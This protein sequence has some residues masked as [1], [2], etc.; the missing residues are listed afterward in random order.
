[1]SSPD[2]ASSGSL[3]ARQR[4]WLHD[5]RFEPRI[6]ERGKVRSLGDG[7]VWIDGLP[8]ASIDEVLLLEDG[9]RAMV[10]H[11]TEDLVGAILLEQ[12]GELTAG[13]LA[14]HSGTRLSIPC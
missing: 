13:K 8:S 14:H 2:K 9:S 3:L 12:T 5:Y 6:V 10:F 11:L 4:D 1:M 7:I